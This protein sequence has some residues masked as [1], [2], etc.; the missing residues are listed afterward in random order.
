[1]GLLNKF[2]PLSL[3]VALSLALFPHNIVQKFAENKENFHLELVSSFSSYLFRKETT[4]QR[5]G[6]K[7]AKLILSIIQQVHVSP[8]SLARLLAAFAIFCCLCYCYSDIAVLMRM[9]ESSLCS[10]FSKKLLRNS[11]TKA[12]GVELANDLFAGC[13]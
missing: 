12:E 8:S 13:A 1:M 11:N 5:N 3:S 9:I 6:W 2:F 4:R 7:T 10:K